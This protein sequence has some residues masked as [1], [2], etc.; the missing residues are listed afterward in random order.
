MLKVITLKKKFKIKITSIC[1]A[2]HKLYLE[3]F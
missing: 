1:K 3:Y 2:Q